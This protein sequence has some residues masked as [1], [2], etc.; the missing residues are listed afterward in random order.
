MKANQ[1]IN[2]YLLT[3]YPQIYTLVKNVDYPHIKHFF[4]DNKKI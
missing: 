3:Y 2:F 1:S 4:L